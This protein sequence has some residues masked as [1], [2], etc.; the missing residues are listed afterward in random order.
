MKRV[1]PNIS[2]LLRNLCVGL[3]LCISSWQ[4]QAQ[5]YL[6]ITPTGVEPAD[7]QELV[8]VVFPADY[9]SVIFAN[10]TPTM[11][12]LYALLVDEDNPLGLVFTKS[13]TSYVMDLDAELFFPSVQSLIF[14]NV[15]GK[16]LY[17]TGTCTNAFVGTADET[18]GF[19]Y[20]KGAKGEKVDVYLDNLQIKTQSK[21]IPGA[22][23]VNK[24]LRGYLLGN[25][26]PIAIGS[27]SDDTNLPF[28]V[29]FHT[30]GNN[31]L[32]GGAT[33]K[34]GDTGNTLNN[35]LASILHLSAASIAVRPI[36]EVP[37]GDASND[38]VA[39]GLER[40]RNIATKLTF[41]DVWPAPT[42]T[43]PDKTIRTN[44][45][46][47]L[48]VE[49]D[50]GAPSIDLGNSKG[51]VEF[52]GGQYKFHTPRTNSM[53]YVSSMAIC[54]RQMTLMGFTTI[55]VGSSVS[56]G[57]A[58]EE[59]GTKGFR[60][61]I[62]NDGTFS[63]YPAEKVA[64]SLDDP[65]PVD[66]VQ[67]GWYAHN[68]DLRVPY[69]TRIY[70]G[71]FTNCEV[72]RCDA[73]GEQGVPPIYVNPSDPFADE[74]SLCRTQIQVIAKDELGCA[75]AFGPLD[76]PKIPSWYAT[77]SLNPVTENDKDYVYIYTPIGCN[78]EPPVYTR[79]WVTLIPKMGVEKM[80]TMGGDQTVYSKTVDGTKDLTNK[81]LFYARLNEYTK[82]NAS[83]RLAGLDVK[84][85]QAIDMIVNAN[86]NPELEFAQ[87]TN[88]GVYTIDQGLYTMLSFPSN[89]WQLISFPYDVHRVYVME[90]TGDDQLRAD[91]TL[92]QFLKR[93]GQADGKL[94][95]NI[96]TSLCPD[97][98]S[99]KGS[100]VN[101]N[102]ID[103]ATEQ[104]DCPP[105][106][107]THYNGK[108]GAESNAKQAHYYL[109]E[110][111]YPTYD[112][113]Q[114]PR[115]DRGWGSWDI[116]SSDDLSANWE[117]V[118]PA[119]PATKY[120]DE[121][122]N[123]ITDAKVLMKAGAIYN[124]FLPSG[125]DRYWDGKYLIF[126][127]FGPQTI[128]GSDNHRGY[129]RVSGGDDDNSV[130][131]GEFIFQGNRTFANF[132]YDTET[133]GN[134]FLPVREGGGGTPYN[135]TFKPYND[136]DNPKV[137]IHPC[138]VYGVTLESG[139]ESVSMRGMITRKK[140]VVTG[141][142]TPV[143]DDI[144]L[145]AYSQAGGLVID[146]RADQYVQVVGIDGRTLFAGQLRQGEQKHIP[147]TTGVY[148]V[149]TDNQAIKLLVER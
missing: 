54:Y 134:I 35:M 127:G 14:S 83:I 4:V 132:T 131:D 15:D 72:Y 143:I 78:P 79:N 117:V 3:L 8:D 52:N 88:S 9:R 55:G 16:K 118:E 57:T 138:E 29:N 71:T 103:I 116:T 80:L 136:P 133:M 113:G 122:G 64:V 26:S 19:I 100:G 130:Y 21:I 2:S 38:V 44:G 105:F 28:Q 41:D 85:Y 20:I 74:T 82:K 53:F 61:V 18:E 36:P 50:L 149:R 65:T 91:E 145:Y 11:D 148:I 6:S 32:V 17:F 1:F 13:G 59:V 22:E 104:I 60:D 128:L 77:A 76:E 102:L 33:S 73:S 140:D 47:E 89:E 49:G 142:S 97:I 123:E 129:I 107:L 111:T 75:T 63:T 69:N 106:Q 45:V 25:A 87:V 126:E 108:N 96:V 37:A 5:T 34:L 42:A 110:Q 135:Y 92:D 70:G 23:G 101:L 48:P 40:Y 10:G 90:T 139:I 58:S 62:F 115:L 109:Y 98:F 39:T 86:D 141:S 27:T 66:V 30:R 68:T 7:F 112:P 137:H 43:D 67:K 46:L 94:A 12:K 93:Q 31:T 144:L 24:W 121:D 56:A 124:L 84:V 146:S 95:Q 51:Q 99:G 119:T 147:A 81:Y 120:Y 114:N 125:K